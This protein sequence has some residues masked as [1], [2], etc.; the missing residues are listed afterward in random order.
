MD[1]RSREVTRSSLLTSY[2][3]ELS[4]GFRVSFRQGNEGDIVSVVQGQT[5]GLH[6]R[7]NNA[8]IVD[9]I[10]V[11]LRMAKKGHCTHDISSENYIR[12]NLL[13]EGLHHN[14]ACI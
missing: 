14:H 7:R 9:L 12:S 13:Q 5:E 11:K 3:D 4:H 10:V 1:V 8:R 6:E 2:L